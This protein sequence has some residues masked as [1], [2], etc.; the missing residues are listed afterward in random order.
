MKKVVFLLKFGKKKHIE[1]LYEKG[2]IFCNTISFFRNFE[3]ND[4]IGDKFEGTT[5]IK[6]S[7]KEVDYKLTLDYKSDKPI[8]LNLSN[9]K[10]RSFYENPKGNLF[11]LYSINL[12]DI[13]QNQQFFI[14]LKMFSNDND[15]C[16]FINKPSDFLK[17]IKNQLDIKGIKF[18]FDLVKYHDFSKDKSNLTL[19]HKSIKYN[20]QKEFRLFLATENIE[21]SFIFNIGD[22]SDIASIHKSENLKNIKIDFI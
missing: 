20:Y 13:N 3:K 7:K 2:T 11:C 6:N 10:M 16:L 15:Y 12:D 21:D 1:N 22:L 8:E 19:F 4:F 5:S 14:D 9:W 18:K 17:R